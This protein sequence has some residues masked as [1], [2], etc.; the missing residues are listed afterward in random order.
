MLH[1][2]YGGPASFKIALFKGESSYTKTQSD[3][4]V[5]EEQ[6]LIAEYDIFDEEQV[7][8]HPVSKFLFSPPK[9]LYVI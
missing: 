6:N 3:D 7:C 2:D 8:S 4:A 1:Q 5:N 9:Y